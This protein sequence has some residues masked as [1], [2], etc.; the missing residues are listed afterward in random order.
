MHKK[1]AALFLLIPILLVSNCERYYHFENGRISGVDSIEELD[2]VSAFS[3]AIMSDNKGDSPTSKPEFARMVKWI[4]LSGCRFVIGLGDHVKKGW[5]NSFLDFIKEN[6]WWSG[7]FYPNIADG[8]NEYYGE[9]QGDWCAGA[10]LLKAA[11]LYDNPYVKMRE[12]GCECYAQIPV[13][14]FTIHL[15][16]LHYPDEPAEEELAFPNSS[17]DYLMNTLN[18]IDKDYGDIVIVAAH[19]RTGFW[20]D[21]L[22]TEQKTV[23]MEKCDMLLS[24]TTHFFE[25]KV[26]KGYENSG[27][28]IINTGSITYPNK[29]CP[30][31]FVYVNV[32]KH[33][34]SLV[35]QYLDA[36]E[37]EREMQWSNY[38]YIKVV[39]GG[40]IETDFRDVK[41]E[42]DF[43]RSVGY[44][45]RS[46][47]QEEMNKVVEGLYLTVGDVDDA[48]INAGSGL[49]GGE[50]PYKD[51]W[52]VFPYN[53]EIYIITLSRTDLEK[54]FENEI[55]QITE[56]ELRIAINN[57]EGDY[58]IKRLNI[59]EERVEKTGIREIN[60]LQKW[61]NSTK[62]G[63]FPLDTEDAISAK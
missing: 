6:K 33:P 39:D 20:I 52:D 1:L 34:L 45:E 26:I 42:E 29:Y 61:L 9:N 19:S 59:P 15:I 35:V 24:A 12:N 51:L 58:L 43:N 3:F 55:D 49:A 4:D 56:P 28:L 2:E 57:F 25:R 22:S 63:D 44:L 60:L 47:T 54:L 16:Q 31:G 48:F 13:E 32:L 7:N 62:Q 14:N 5:E 50:I 27:P 41:P 11:N 23:V 37:E 18:S 21:Q 53:N 36:S 46:Y 38:A 8:E 17:R 40:I 30:P 10:P